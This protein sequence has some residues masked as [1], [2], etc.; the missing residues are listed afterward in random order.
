MPKLLVGK[1]VGPQGPQGIQ[2]VKGDIGLTGPQGIQGI[3]GPQGEVGPQGPKGNTGATGLKGDT[4]ATGPQGIQGL[5][6]PQGIQGPKGDTGATGATGPQGKQG[7]QGEIGPQGLQGLKGDTGLTGPQGIQGVQGAKGDK[8][9]I[10]LTG[11]TGPQGIKG[12]QGIQGETGPQGERGLQGVIGLTGPQGVKGDTGATGGKGATGLTGPQGIQGPQGERGLQGVQGPQ[13]IQGI[14]GSKTYNVNTTPS[15]S[16]G[17]VG[18]FALNTV[19]GDVYEKTAST[20]WTKNG[21]FRGPQGLTGPQG[22]TGPQGTTGLTGAKGDTGATGLTGPQGAKGDTGATGTQGIQGPKGNT[23]DTGI[24]GPK[25]DTGATGPQGAQGV[26]GNDGLTVSVNSVKHVNGNITLTPTSIGAASSSHTHD[27]RYYTETEINTKFSNTD[28]LLD[29]CLKFRSQINSLNQLDKDGYYYVDLGDETFPYA[30]GIVT[31]KTTSLGTKVITYNSTGVDQKTYTNILKLGQSVWEGWKQLATTEVFEERGY[32]TSKIYSGSLDDLG[33]NGYYSVV[34]CTTEQKAPV[35]GFTGQIIVYTHNHGNRV[36]QFALSEDGRFFK[37]YML[38]DYVWRDW[39][40]IATTNDLNDKTYLTS[41]GG[42][43]EY[44]VPTKPSDYQPDALTVRKLRTCSDIG[45]GQYGF[46]ATL[47]GI[48]SHGASNCFEMG[49][50]NDGNMIYRKQNGINDSW[51]AWQEIA[52]TTK[53][54]IAFPYTSGY[55]GYYSGYQSIVAK[56]NNHVSC[57]LT[58]KKTDSSAMNGLITLGTLPVGYR[59]TL[60]VGVNGTAGVPNGIEIRSNGQVIVNV[61][62]TTVYC[63]S[64]DYYVD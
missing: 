19:N 45:G 26:Q 39:E 3:A 58:F 7:I 41:G 17:V 59:P 61:P 57:N 12:D 25:G 38:Y 37:R 35:N 55:T 42:S 2:G 1:V 52:T 23:G 31:Q 28:N 5:V 20:T 43:S 51:D 54:Q 4:G 14:A 11:P 44:Y 21:N 13:G 47:L 48:R 22:A 27:D 34:S 64:F 40:Q 24:Q 56:C 32:S 62:N 46:W 49:F 36:V 30:Y 9:D 15:T 29:A 16:L 53:T 33:K 18:D 10:G 60:H 63:L 6:G 8:G 50:T